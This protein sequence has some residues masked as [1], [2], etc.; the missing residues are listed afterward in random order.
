MKDQTF[1]DAESVDSD[2]TERMLRLTRV[3]AWRTCNIVGFVMWRLI[4]VLISP[5][6]QTSHFTSDNF[7]VVKYMLEEGNPLDFKRRSCSAI[8]KPH[9]SV[10]INAH[11]DAGIV[12]H[13]YTH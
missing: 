10:C 2:Q 7:S 13:S 5:K 9:C 3:F 12:G 11:G 1:I 6:P 8:E 4:F